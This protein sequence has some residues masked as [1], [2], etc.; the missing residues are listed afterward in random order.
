MLW[1]VHNI[2]IVFVWGTDANCYSDY[3]FLLQK[4]S[5]RLI[6]NTHYLAHDTKRIFTMC[7][8][9]TLHIKL[10]AVFLQLTEYEIFGLAY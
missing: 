8:I 2:C 9:V 7:I 10:E 1:F 5:L 6:V 3:V 4:Q